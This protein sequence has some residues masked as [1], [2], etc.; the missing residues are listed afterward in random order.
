[1]LF[2]NIFLCSVTL[3][4]DSDPAH[5]LFGQP[6]YSGYEIIGAETFVT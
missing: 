6:L 1:M 5:Y 2:I 4:S 3:Y